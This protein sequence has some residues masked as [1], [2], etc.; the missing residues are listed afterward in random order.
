MKRSSEAVSPV[1]GVLLLLGV[2][3][4]FVALTSNVLFSTFDS[5]ASP[6]TEIEIT[7]SYDSSGDN[8]E[9]VEM[10][11][12]RN[13]NVDRY[14]VIGEDGGCTE[15]GITESGNSETVSSGTACSGRS[16]VSV[17]NG[18]TL[19]FRGHVGSGTFVLDTY[20]IPS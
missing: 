5:S 11:I 7:H 9:Q 13:Q 17:S 2:T 4:A 8:V 12:V 20:R 10:T 3:V 19:S 1:I 15:F 18:D 14:T 16:A 6:Q